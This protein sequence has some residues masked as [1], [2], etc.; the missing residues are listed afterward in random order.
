MNPKRA[1]SKDSAVDKIERGA[2]DK[3]F[4]HNFKKKDDH[5]VRLRIFVANPP[6]RTWGKKC[7]RPRVTL[8]C[9][10]LSE[11]SMMQR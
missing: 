4:N 5:M 7:V 11:V 8:L 2:V 6:V 10:P 3:L 1:V 9:L